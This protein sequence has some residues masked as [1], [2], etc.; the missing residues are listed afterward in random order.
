MGR[1]SL[2]TTGRAVTLLNV[3]G[4]GVVT[5]LQRQCG[6]VRQFQRIARL[7]C[8]AICRQRAARDV[9]VDPSTVFHVER[10]TFRPIEE[11][12]ENARVLMNQHRLLRTIRRSDEAQAAALL[13]RAKALLLVAR[14]DTLHTRLYP[15]LQK[16]HDVCR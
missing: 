15:D 8:H 9:H 6:S 4:F 1:A 5:V 14:L 16:V 10:G 12:R 2:S 3:N 13:V 7:Q 11:A